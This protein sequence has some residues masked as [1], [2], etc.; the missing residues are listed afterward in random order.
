VQA[1][2]EPRPRVALRAPGRFQ[3]RNFALAITAAQALLGSLEPEAVSEVAA[4]LTIPGRLEV[5][6]DDPLTILD[7]AHNPDGAAALADALPE[8]TGG[9]PVFACVGILAD[10]DAAGMIRE[11]APALAHAVC[12]ELPPDR[13]RASGRPGARSWPAPELAA[14]S[15]EQGLAAESIEDPA[16]AMTRARQLAR[17]RDGIALATGSHY[18]LGSA[19]TRKHAQSYSR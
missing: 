2:P 16:T 1:P 15:A 17:A 4:S 12:T 9:S 11:L 13:L 19:W 8:V 3:R 7:A 18:L 5:V 14:I 10:K 6:A